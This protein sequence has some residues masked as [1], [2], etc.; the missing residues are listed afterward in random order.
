MGQPTLD[1]LFK[2]PIVFST[3]D[4]PNIQSTF[5]GTSQEF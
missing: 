5:E 4:K 1:L 3:L 2:D